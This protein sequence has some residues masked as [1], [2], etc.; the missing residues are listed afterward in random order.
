MK[1][2][3]ISKNDAEIMFNSKI[4]AL[5]SL[6]MSAYPDLFFVEKEWNDIGVIDGYYIE[7]ACNI[8]PVTGK[9]SS[10][11]RNIYPTKE[12]AERE[13]A[14][15][16]LL[17]WRDIANGEKLHKWCNWEQ[18]D[19]KYCIFPYENKWSTCTSSRTRHSLAF[20]SF[21]IRDEFIKH[22]KSLINKAFNL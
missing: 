2:I 7:S 1:T 3:E 5:I 16:Q 21:T 8:I 11:N 13:L 20:K 15:I 4:P 9:A 6:A 17:Q 19:S 18:D 14:L 10:L 12:E 22:H